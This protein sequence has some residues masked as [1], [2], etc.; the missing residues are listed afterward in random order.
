MNSSLTPGIEGTYRRCVVTEHLVSHHNPGGAPVLSTP[1]LL[2]FM[3][4]AAW[5]AMAPHLN[6]GDDSVGVGFEFQHLAP[7]PAGM[8]VTAQAVVTKVEGRFVTLTIEARDE[9]ELIAKGQHVRAVITL[10]RFKE[11]LKRKVEQPNG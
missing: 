5:Q 1:H 3:E 2:G 8:T 4:A 7:T 11:R 6:A 10:E 9:Q